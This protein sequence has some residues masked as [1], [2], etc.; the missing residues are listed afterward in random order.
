[1]HA[2][3]VA[4]TGNKAATDN[5]EKDIAAAAPAAETVAEAPEIEPAA[6]P[7]KEEPAKVNFPEA[8]E[9]DA[10]AAAE[11]KSESAV[12]DS[13]PAD[14]SP[15][16]VAE[17]K[18]PVSGSNGHVGTR[19]PLFS[20]FNPR[21]PMVFNRNGFPRKNADLRIALSELQKSAEPRPQSAE[22]KPEPAGGT[23]KPETQNAAPV[24]EGNKES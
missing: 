20:R 7:A 21:G 3:V 24:P 8:A 12:K 6:E 11:E 9:A 19:K 23:A 10:A 13:A 15:K 22:T 2:E 16:P 14:N 4:E 18:P 17:D 1:M 5:T